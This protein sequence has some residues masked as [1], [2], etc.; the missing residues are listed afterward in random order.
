MSEKTNE[1]FVKTTKGKFITIVSNKVN[2]ENTII[3][4]DI[5][6]QKYEADR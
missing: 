1:C 6:G 2:E 4:D 3:P 5:T